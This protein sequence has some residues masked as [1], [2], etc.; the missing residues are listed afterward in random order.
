M[1]EESRREDSYAEFAELAAA[2]ARGKYVL[3]LY[4]SGMTPR[5]TE[6]IHNLKEICEQ[7]LGDESNYELQI[8]DLYKHPE[9][10]SKDHVIATPTLVKREPGAVRRLVGTLT[11]KAR[12][13]AGLDL[14]R[15]KS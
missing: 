10:A 4:I 8:I 15:S 2:Q 7:Y 14:G 13:L 5:S 11:D 1:A 12:V 3:C 9:L 6:A